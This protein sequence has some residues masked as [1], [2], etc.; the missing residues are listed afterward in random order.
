[1][2]HAEKR[3]LFLL[4][5]IKFDK[6]SVAADHGAP[7]EIIYQFMEW[8]KTSRQPDITVFLYENDNL[9]RPATGSLNVQTMLIVYRTIPNKN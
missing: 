9:G 8:L 2:L 4:D 5:E 3:S 7:V 6:N 1:L